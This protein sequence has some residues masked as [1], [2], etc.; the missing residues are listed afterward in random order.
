MK[1]QAKCQICKKNEAVYA[2]QYI[3]EEK[4]SFYRLGSHIR[5][6]LVIKVCDNCR[7]KEIEKTNGKN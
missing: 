5:G 4:P 3:A 2:M 1:I 7:V 6:F